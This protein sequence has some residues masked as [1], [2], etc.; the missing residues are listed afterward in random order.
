MA[1]GKH[2]ARRTE[3]TRGQGSG[4]QP[5]GHGTKER[6]DG[7]EQRSL[8][9][10]HPLSLR[11][12]ARFSLCTMANWKSRASA[13]RHGDHGITVK[14]RTGRRH[15]WVDHGQARRVAEDGE[16]KGCLCLVWPEITDARKPASLSQKIRCFDDA[17]SEAVARK[18]CRSTRVVYP[19]N[20]TPLPC[21]A[22]VRR[23][24]QGLSAFHKLVLQ[25]KKI[26]ESEPRVEAERRA[27]AERRRDKAPPVGPPWNFL[28]GSIVVPRGGPTPLGAKKT[29]LLRLRA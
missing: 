1:I 9:T 6:T 19:P 7:R 26:K 12:C 29:L 22:Q 25:E 2:R 5:P 11:H 21:Q 4:H 3:I 8:L 10:W 15:W 23:D 27:K 28:I 17:T 13:R 20:P 14:V 24:Y 16:Q 18:R